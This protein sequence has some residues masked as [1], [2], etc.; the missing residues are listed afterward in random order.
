MTFENEAMFFM[1][2]EFGRLEN[3]LSLYCMSLCRD[4][5]K[6]GQ[7]LYRFLTGQQFCIRHSKTGH[8]CFQM[9]LLA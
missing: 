1:F 3:E 2:L 5:S 7:N 8:F 9:V 4:H 6:S